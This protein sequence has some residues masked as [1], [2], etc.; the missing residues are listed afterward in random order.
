MWGWIPAVDPSRVDDTLTVVPEK[1]ESLGI[2]ELFLGKFID[3]LAHQFPVARHKVVRCVWWTFAG[4]D[5]V[6][7]QTGVFRFESGWFAGEVRLEP[8]FTG[9]WHPTEGVCALWQT[10][11][12]FF[13]K[14]R[15]RGE[16]LGAAPL[17]GTVGNCLLIHSVHSCQASVALSFAAKS[18]ME[19]GTIGIFRQ[20]T[21]H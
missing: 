6:R 5:S 15:R 8:M 18:Q 4:T 2:T 1:L 7:G 3:I 13:A 12:A 9:E 17:W 19:I 20:V 16:N 10:Q 14:G 11:S 21:F